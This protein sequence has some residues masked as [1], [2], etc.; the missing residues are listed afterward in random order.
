MVN[1]FGKK[2]NLAE[3]LW[4]CNRAIERFVRKQ[5]NSSSV[6]TFSQKLVSNDHFPVDKTF[7]DLKK[8]LHNSC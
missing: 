6:Y 1:F 8:K 7:A 5:N 4:Y 2:I 3:S